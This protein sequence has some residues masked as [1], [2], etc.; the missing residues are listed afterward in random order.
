MNHANRRPQACLRKKVARD[1]KYSQEP[2]ERI[3]SGLIAIPCGGVNRVVP[4][5]RR[6][7]IHGVIATQP[8][9]VKGLDS[10]ATLCHRNLSFFFSVL[11]LME[12]LPKSLIQ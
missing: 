9:S 5:A 6:L 3:P 4:R 8:L 11:L 10:G 12:G 1:P 7:L 2:V